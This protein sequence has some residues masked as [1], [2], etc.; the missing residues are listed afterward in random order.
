MSFSSSHRVKILMND[1]IAAQQYLSLPTSNYS[2]L[3]SNVISRN[4]N[5]SDT[6]Q[7]SLPLGDLTS[8]TG[9][10]IS[11]TLK[12]SIKVIPDIDKG[13][14]TFQSGPFYFLPTLKNN[15]SSSINN[16]SNDDVDLQKGLP[17]WL[18]WGGQQGENGEVKS[19]IQA[20]FT[21]ELTWKPPSID[22]NI[23]EMN[24][25]QLLVNANV[26][27]FVDLNVPIREDLARAISFLPV[28]ILLQQAGSL[29]MNAA[30]RSIAP[31]FSELLKKDHDKRRNIDINNN[32]DNSNMDNSKL[33]VDSSF[34]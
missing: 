8:V 24:N 34:N 5:D 25:D 6:F 7:M 9:I 30:L 26:K 10:T 28:K 18:L 22:T 32:I 16:I 23:N 15:T 27:V 11:A 33:L 4:D 3:N 21:T 31:T 14:L 13:K 19:S 2:L 17:E 20:G 12:T 29:T 1:S